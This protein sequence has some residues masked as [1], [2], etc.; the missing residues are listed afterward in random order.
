MLISYVAVVTVHTDHWLCMNN[1]F[2]PFDEFTQ[3]GPQFAILRETIARNELSR[4]FC[5]FPKKASEAFVGL[6][7]LEALRIALGAEIEIDH[8][9]QQGA[10]QQNN[11]EAGL[12]NR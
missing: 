10:A 2:S 4:S 7:F 5:P 9:F 1:R 3:V 8:T 6:D 11:G 12:L